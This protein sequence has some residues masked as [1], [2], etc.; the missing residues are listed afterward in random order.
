MNQEILY[1]E[2]R[3]TEPGRSQ[4][5]MTDLINYGMPLIRYETGDLAIP[6]QGT[7]PCGRGLARIGDI[8]GRVIDLLPTRSGGYVNGQLFATFHWIE[9]V[10]QYQVVQ[11]KMD[12]FRIRIVPQ[13]AFK[14][15]NL[16]SI[17]RTIRENFG[18]DTSIHIEYLENI[19]F[20]KGG[21]Y[22]LI[23]S[24]VQ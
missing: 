16:D 18:D 19:P 2:Y 9:G 22:K 8:E 14:E 11:E 15:T 21:K 7:C 12:A 23:V 3:R 17:V 20:T 13:P 24:E 1:A 10:K 5:I 6:L 4:L